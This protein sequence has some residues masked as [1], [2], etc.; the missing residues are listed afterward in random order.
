MFI[1]GLWKTTIGIVTLM[2]WSAMASAL[3]ACLLIAIAATRAN[4]EIMSNAAKYT[5]A[6]D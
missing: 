5:S 1:A 6:H 3:S 4:R 2:L